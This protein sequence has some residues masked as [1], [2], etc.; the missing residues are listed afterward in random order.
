[1]EL[2]LKDTIAP[3]QTIGRYLAG[4]IEGHDLLELSAMIKDEARVFSFIIH[5][6]LEETSSVR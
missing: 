5:P 1:V 2:G 3:G 6:E 4:M